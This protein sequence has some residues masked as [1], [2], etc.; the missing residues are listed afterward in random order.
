MDSSALNQKSSFHARSNSLPSAPHPLIPQ[1]DEHLCRLKSNEAATSLSSIT[2]RLN[3][4]RDLY[5]LVNSWLQLPST[6]N[7]LVQ[8]SNDNEFLN[9]S[10]RL[11]DVCGLA[12]DALL[13][14]KEDTQQLQSVFRRRR[15]DDS[16]FANE[17]K[18][19]LASRKKANKLINKSLKDLKISKCGG[20]EAIFSMLRN[21]EGVT[22]SVLQSV[23][24]Y[25]TASIPEQKST[26]WSLVSKLMHSKRITCE[27][28]ASGSNKFEIVKAILCSLVGSKTK[29]ENVQIELQN[30]ESSIQDVEDGVECLIR[31]L[32]KTRVSILNIL[33]H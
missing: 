23:F 28:R 18:A 11:L 4:L 10:L 14:A 1:I 22:F 3:G 29:T 27:G 31:L 26:N 6:Q 32:I 9:G 19:Y 5:E 20:V 25:I 21:V 2:N 24:C 12:K 33:S 16:G 17:V 15:G 8:N 30:L 7:S 13:Q